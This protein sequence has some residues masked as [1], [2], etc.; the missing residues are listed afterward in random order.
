[1]QISFILCSSICIFL[2]GTLFKTGVFAQTYST[3]LNISH[4]F[5]FCFQLE[6][7]CVSLWCKS[8][9]T[10]CSL[11][12]SAIYCMCLG[13]REEKCIKGYLWREGNLFGVCSN[14]KIGIDASFK[15][16][17][18]QRCWFLRL[19]SGATWRVQRRET[20]DKLSLPSRLYQWNGDA[21]AGISAI[22][23]GSA[24]HYP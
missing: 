2:S 16:K 9:L 22:V 19:E 23:I 14:A 17:Q 3:I 10:L 6:T 24:C 13:L 12:L 15:C 21:G 7:A 5:G 8:S 11:N 18:C 4:T 20:S 1:M